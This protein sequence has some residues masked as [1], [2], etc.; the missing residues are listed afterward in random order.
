MMRAKNTCFRVR[1]LKYSLI[2]DYK[3]LQLKALILL[4]FQIIYSVLFI[5][6]INQS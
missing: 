4:T 3:S 6:S 1:D 2:L 5:Q